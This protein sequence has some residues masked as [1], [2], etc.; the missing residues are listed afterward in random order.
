MLIGSAV[1]FGVGLSGFVCHS[2][3]RERRDRNGMMTELQSGTWA[4]GGGARHRG[5]HR[6][7][8]RNLPRAAGHDSERR[9][10]ADGFS[11]LG[12]RRRAF[13]RRR[14]HLRR[15]GG[16]HARRRRRIRL[17]DRGLR[18]AVGISLQL[19]ADVGG[20]ERL[21]RHAGHRIFR[22]HGAL[23]SGIREG[24]VHRRARFR[25]NTAR[26]SRWS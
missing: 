15:T 17:S 12:G 11:G 7:R 6:D 18:A 10:R 8:Q 4:S 20:K 13:A 24:L 19:D 14:A 23:R 26:Y 2:R 5:R 22:I 25:S 21:D 9:H 1:T 16:R 3:A